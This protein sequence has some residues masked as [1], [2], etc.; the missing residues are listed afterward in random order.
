VDAKPHATDLG[1]GEL[2]HWH[3]NTELRCLARAKRPRRKAVGCAVAVSWA[4]LRWCDRTCPP[5]GAGPPMRQSRGG[6]SRTPKTRQRPPQ[7]QHR[8]DRSTPHAK[9]LGAAR[10]RPPGPGAGTREGPPRQARQRGRRGPP[11][12]QG[13][14]PSWGPGAISSPLSA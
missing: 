3:R 5:P 8:P 7:A 11:M 4:I 6:R 2:K 14:R 1:G 12:R 13:W 9:A 10:P